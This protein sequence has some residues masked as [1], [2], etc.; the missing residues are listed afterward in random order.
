MISRLNLTRYVIGKKKKKQ[1]M[2]MAHSE[3]RKNDLYIP[4]LDSQ[5]E[6]HHLRTKAQSRDTSTAD[7]TREDYARHYTRDREPR[8]GRLRQE[9]IS[10]SEENPTATD[11][12]NAR[13]LQNKS[14]FSRK[15]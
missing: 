3:A 14:S 4:Y 2:R 8:S 11:L 9:F 12:T 7:S 6:L 15:G 10:Q 1:W 13:Q 5:P